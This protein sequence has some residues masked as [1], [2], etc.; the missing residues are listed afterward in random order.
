MCQTVFSYAEARDYLRSIGVEI[1]EQ[2]LRRYVSDGRLDC[3]RLPG[4]TYLEK[5][6]L[7]GWIDR[8]RV[9][10]KGTLARAERR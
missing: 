8:C 2:T 10:A 7:D 5:E 6:A 9:A 1:A 3:V 4:R